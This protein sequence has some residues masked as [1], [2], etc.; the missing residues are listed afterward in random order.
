MD[1]MNPAIFKLVVLVGIL[2]VVL[3]LASGLIWLERRLLALWQDRYGPNRV[4]PFGLLQVLADMIKIFFK[5]DWIPPFADKWVFVMAPAIIM[6]TVLLTFAVVPFTP[7]VQ[8]AE[9]NV[10][11]LFFLGMS[12]LASTASCWG[13]GRRTTST[14]CWGRCGPLRRC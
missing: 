3:T 8:I 1:A 5:E 14:R 10:A 12:S 13:A 6:V 4:G 11:L 2:L 9:T 7:S